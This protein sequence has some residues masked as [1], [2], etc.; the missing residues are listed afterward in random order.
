MSFY[1]YDV[2]Y[3]VCVN[4]QPLKFP[5]TIF[6]EAFLSKIIRRGTK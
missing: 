3:S 4:S 1:V 6:L 2:S 5:S